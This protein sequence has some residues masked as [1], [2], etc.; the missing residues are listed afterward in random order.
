MHFQPR[1]RPGLVV[2]GDVPRQHAPHVRLAGDEEVVEARRAGRPDPA[3][4]RGVGVRRA[5]RRAH[6]RD[7]R[8]REDGVAGRRGRRVAIVAAAPGRCARLLH[9]PGALARLRRDPGGGRV[10][11]AAG[12]MHP[13]GADRKAEADVRRLHEPRLDGAAV[14]GQH[15]IAMRREEVPPGARASA[16]Q[17]RRREVTPREDSA[18]RRAPAG[19]AERGRLALEPR[20]A[21]ARVLRGQSQEQ[22]RHLGGQR[23]PS[24]RAA[25]PLGPLL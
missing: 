7:P 18:D 15:G 1:Q 24:A 5:V 25:P 20:V 23:R 4:R 12:E 17:R 2:A 22:R 6:D 13:A 8:G 3:R 9:R 21:P 14:A 19:V 10:G 11:G 16:A